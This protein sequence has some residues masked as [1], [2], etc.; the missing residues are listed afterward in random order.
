MNPSIVHLARGLFLVLVLSLVPGV[1]G[2]APSQHPHT[3]ALAA[4]GA[5]S[6]F[7]DAVSAGASFAAAR[8][9]E[10]P[11]GDT[12]NLEDDQEPI[13]EPRADIV[14][15]CADLTAQDVTLTVQVAEPTDPEADQNWLGSSATWFLDTDRDGEGEFTASLFISDQTGDP[16]V[17]VQDLALAEVVCEGDYEF[18]DDAIKLAF[19]SDCLGSP[20]TLAVSPGIVYDQR[21]STTTG[22]AVLDFAPNAGPL[23]TPER[24][25]G[26]TRFETAVAASQRY[27]DGSRTHVVLSRSDEFADSQ[28]GTPLALLHDAP[29][30][31]TQTGELHPATRAEMERVLEDGGTVIVLGGTAAIDDTV[32]TTIEGMGYTVV[33][34]GGVNRF[35][36]ATIIAEQG[37]AMPTTVLAADGG[38]FVPSLL[39][40]TA[41]GQLPQGAEGTP[42]AVLLTDGE[43]LPDE[44]AAYLAEVVEPT[45]VAIG[46]AAAAAVPDADQTITGADEFELSV[47]V[48]TTL[49]DDPTVAGL[50]TNADFADALVA[51]SALNDGEDSGPLLFTAPNELP[52]VV[53][54]YLEATDSITRLL[55]FGG[56][57]AIG[58]AVVDQAEDALER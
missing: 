30:L 36:T 20:S 26:T 2:A 24:F 53:E 51:G 1:G 31:L 33:R 39:A 5:G 44:T 56:N 46:D 9:F 42:A 47:N 48:A 37:L 23:L 45:V 3:A 50:A 6:T 38:D 17:E 22:V 41:S 43:R 7:T 16:L 49:Y 8:C 32:V 29:I 12:V 14:S 54:D 28:T 34:Y 21:I 58:Q 4:H 11:A 18:A 15:H 25:A 35:E 57:L 13:D 55:V 27:A 19:G 40:G 52:E 10:D